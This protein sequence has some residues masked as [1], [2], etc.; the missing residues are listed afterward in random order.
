VIDNLRSAVWSLLRWPSR[1][2]FARSLEARDFALPSGGPVLSY[3][4]ALPRGPGALV[5]GGRVKLGHLDRIFPENGESF[6]VLYLVSSAQPRF[7]L[8]LVRWARARGVKFVWNQNGVAFPAWA[9]AKL[10]ETNRPMTALRNEADFVVYQ[11]DFCRESAERFLGSNTTPS[12][13]LFNPV[14]LHEFSPAPSSEPVTR[15]NLLT[16]GTHYQP[17][18]VLG[19]IE[20]LEHL[21]KSGCPAHLTVAGALCWPNAEAEVQFAIA[22]R[23]LT[24]AVTLRPAFSQAEAVQLYRDAHVLIHPKYHD[25]CPTVVIEALAC[26]LPVIGSRTGGLPEL[27]GNDGGELIEVPLSWERPAA[28]PPFEIARAVMKVMLDWPEQSRAAR[29]RAERLFDA[30]QWIA[31]HREIFEKLLT[32]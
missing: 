19:P 18:R 8:Q 21:R 30:S 9:G 2:A 23:G 29:A 7:A 3:G 28:L 32:A 24:G 5:A 22:R 11:S 14:D 6:N 17:G 16:A 26:G 27:V 25:P 4:G 20:A 12:K 31:A 15:W 13:V 1:N 10:A